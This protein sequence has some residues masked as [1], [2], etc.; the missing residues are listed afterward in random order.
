MARHVDDW[1]EL[2]ESTA[3]KHGW[4]L[5]DVDRRGFSSVEVHGSSPEIT[6]DVAILSFK[7]DFVLRLDHAL[8][9]YYVLKETSP[10][11]FSYWQMEKW[12]N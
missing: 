6:D 7:R 9:G 2:F 4:T 8:Q 5:V 1:L 10:S 11:E 3:L 12:V